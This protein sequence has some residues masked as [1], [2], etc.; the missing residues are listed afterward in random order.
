LKPPDNVEASE[1]VNGNCDNDSQGEQSVD[2]GHD[3]RPQAEEPK[4]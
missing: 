3:L 1:R 4:I 2:V